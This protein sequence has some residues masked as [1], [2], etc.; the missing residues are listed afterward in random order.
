MQVT[1]SQ[2]R[3]ASLMRTLLSHV[4][5]SLAVWWLLG[6]LSQIGD[7]WLKNFFSSFLSFLLAG[8]LQVF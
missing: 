6:W 7:P 3:F 8:I 2:L 4:T 5:K 1:K